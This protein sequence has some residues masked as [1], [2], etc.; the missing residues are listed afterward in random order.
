MS[1]PGGAAV[2]A[3]TPCRTVKMKCIREPDSTM[4]N[5]CKRKSLTCYYE[6]HRRGRKPGTKLRPKA[7]R[8]KAS[9]T[10]SAL[11]S[12]HQGSNP[13]T[14]SAAEPT[15][16]IEREDTLSQHSG[17]LLI[18]VK[19]HNLMQINRSLAS[20]SLAPFALLRKSATVGNF[21]IANILNVEEETPAGE[22]TPDPDVLGQDDLP[23]K[24]P[25]DP[26][27]RNLLSMPSAQGLFD[28]FF[29]YMNPFIC[30]FDPVMH[31][32]RYVRSRSP[33]LFSAL[34]AAAAKVFSPQ[35]Y[36]KLHDHVE[37]LLRKILGS[38]EK[39]TEIVQGICLV[40]HWK[41]PSDSRAWMLVGY[42]IRACMEMGWH[43]I[44][45]THLDPVF[46][47]GNR[48][49]AKEMELRERRNKERTWLMLFVYDRSVSLQLGR[50]SM[51]HMDHLIRNAETWHQHAYAV[52]GIDEV[53]VSFV[54]LRILGFDLLDVFWLHPVA[55]TSQ[56]IDKDEFIL[57]TFNSELDR[58]EAKWYRILDEG[59]GPEQL[60]QPRFLTFVNAVASSSVC[61]RFL[62]RFYGNHLR[63]LIHSFRLQLSI[64]SGNVSKESL[65]ICYSSA[66]EMLRLVVHR[67]GMVSHLYYCQDSVHVMVAYAAVV[68]IKILL[69]LPGELSAESEATILD[70]LCKASED[71]GRQCSA[72]NTNCFYQSR[73]LAN[74]VTQF[75]KSKAK[76]NPPTSTLIKQHDGSQIPDP[77][78][79]PS[80]Q[81]HQTGLI[82]QQQLQNQ[83]PLEPSPS[84]HYPPGPQQRLPSDM[85]PLP[86]ASTA[87]SIQFSAL[88]NPLSQQHSQVSPSDASPLTASMLH[89]SMTAAANPIQC[90]SNHP[91]NPNPTGMLCSDAPPPS[92]AITSSNGFQS[93]MPMNEVSSGDGGNNYAFASFTDTGAWENLFAH[94]GFNINSGAFI[95]NLEED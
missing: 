72:N 9:N 82:Q 27:N 93:F 53:M 19:H 57:K 23:M 16:K 41:E 92:A 38:G 85:Y 21:T 33:F 63:L 66:L 84:S 28:N 61:H 34:L 60:F 13:P 5:R 4:C 24:D 6:T 69:S 83:S 30:Q 56:T 64:L 46:E 14:A 35:L 65:W 42:A 10:A 22:E 1:T 29:K 31:T 37:F 43:K 89:A 7:E 8:M 94:A 80:L 77:Y 71:F 25:D 48:G 49:S 86:H 73:F 11:T 40:T 90:M 58:W 62:V 81:I 74:V 68:I 18:D 36:L 26:V 3:C 59:N 32:L 55:T 78:V 47:D 95:P 50:P 67:L 15:P 51:I 44:S 79:R 12:M 70:L 75:R 2:A 54:Q 52:P 76:A 20:D 17:H 45:P 39:S 87:A 91:P 88:N